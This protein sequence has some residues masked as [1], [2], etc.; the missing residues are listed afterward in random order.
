MSGRAEHTFQFPAAAIAK[1]AQEK[2]GYHANRLSYWQGEYDTSVARVEETIGAKV[3]K[4]PVTNG[5]TVSVVI[6]YGD[7]AAYDRMLQ[8]FNR[9]Q[10]HQDALKQYKAEAL[11][12]GTQDGRVYELTSSD[13]AYFGLDGRDPEDE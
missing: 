13:V 6:D 11:V 7:R 1:A 9:M 3:E 5:Y 8:A 2:I 12:Y 4:H 10:D